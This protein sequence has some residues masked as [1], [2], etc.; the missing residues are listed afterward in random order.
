M[1]KKWKNGA[2]LKANKNAVETK[3]CFQVKVITIQCLA[4]GA[5]SN[6]I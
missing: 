4:C 5:F 1:L 2:I 3:K 6:A